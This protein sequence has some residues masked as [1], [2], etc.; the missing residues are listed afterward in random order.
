LL[1][2]PVDRGAERTDDGVG[3]R[4]EAINIRKIKGKRAK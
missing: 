4:N 1:L 3:W 2:V